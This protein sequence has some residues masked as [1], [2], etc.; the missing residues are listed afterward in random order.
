MANN[1]RNVIGTLNRR[2]FM[3]CAVGAGLAVPSPILAA[4][5][6]RSDP[7]R[8]LL[9][10]ADFRLLGYY[11]IQTN[12]Q[13]TTYA[14]G[15]T[16]RYVGGD[17]RFLN[18]QHASRLDEF[19]LAG[20]EYGS[21]ITSPTRSWNRIG[22]MGDF[23]GFWWDEAKA[24]LW[25]VSATDYTAEAL[26]V[27]IFT[28][29][30][31]D[32][33]TVGDVRGPV[34]LR[35]IPA[36]R[37]Y[38]G[39]QPVPAWFQQQYGVGPYV[40]GWGGYASLVASGGTASMGPTMYAIPDPSGY[41]NSTDVPARAFKTL[42]DN[43]SG[44]TQGDW[45]DRR[46]PSGFDRGSRVTIPLNYFDGGDPRPNP[47]T[48]P[49]GP[50]DRRGQWL[51]PSPDGFGRFVWGD[52]Y[53]NTGQWIDGADKHGFVM[54]ASLGGGKCWYQSS[55]L[56]FDRR[57]FELHIFDPVTLGEAARGK[58]S[59]WKVKPASMTELTLPGLGGTWGGNVPVKNIGGATYDA[60]TKR[61]YLIGFGVNDFLQPLV[62]VSGRLDSQHARPSPCA[63]DGMAPPRR[64]FSAPERRQTP[65]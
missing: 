43:S 11:D 21:V 49:T 39:A 13:D 60:V 10:P 44:S 62:R 33:G 22:G 6:T 32:D 61:L 47:N 7:T 28:R 48:P 50:P 34:G 4:S 25:S 58:L 51:S 57:V 53:Y 19:S 1:L 15:L 54:V 52:S 38:G 65:H 20:K 56:E 17:L 30:L 27:R 45:Y 2:E 24:R 16:H 5:Q 55:T 37:V 29:T 42:M 14:Q 41:A 9:S 12:G 36:K 35:G 64:P 40:V 8:A 46:S 23:K 3:T 63:T 59:P 18:F 31:N 26:P